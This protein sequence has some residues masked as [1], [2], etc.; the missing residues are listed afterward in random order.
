MGF[1]KIKKD[2]D[3]RLDYPYDMGPLLVPG[4][5]IVSATVAVTESAPDEALVVEPDPEIA[6]TVIIPWIN[7][8]TEGEKYDVTYHFATF[9][10]REDDRTRTLDVKER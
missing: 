10:G 6:G 1:P 3:A 8:G 4:D 7:G 9:E 5:S 2:P